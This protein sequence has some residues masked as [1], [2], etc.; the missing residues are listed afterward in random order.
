MIIGDPL[1]PAV[2]LEVQV[3][4]W[5]ADKELYEDVD[6]LAPLDAF[7]DDK[8]RVRV[9]NRGGAP[10]DLTILYVESA[11]R[12]RSYFPTAMQDLSGDFNNRLAPERLPGEGAP[13]E[14]EFTV[15]DS[16]IGLEDVI[17]IATVIV[18]FSNCVK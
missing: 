14:V 16:T 9:Y 13:A 18:R 8:L 5:N 7:D 2:R 15:N 3:A 6:P 17:I 4:R 10:V 1:D 11:F 12:I